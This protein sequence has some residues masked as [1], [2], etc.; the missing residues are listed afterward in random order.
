MIE[1]PII[2]LQLNKDKTEAIIIG[3]TAKKMKLRFILI[4]CLYSI[5]IKPEIFVSLWMPTLILTAISI[6]SQDQLF[7]TQKKS[8][9]TF[10]TS[11]LYYSKGL[12]SSLPQKTIR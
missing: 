12:F 11:R 6:A 4:L 8:G 10:V 5:R 3:S 9:A 2:F 7:I 1:C